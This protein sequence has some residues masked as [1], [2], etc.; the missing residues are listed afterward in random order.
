MLDIDEMSTKEMHDFLQKVGHGHLGCTFEGHP[1][2]VPM[3][4]YFG[5]PNIYI[6]TTIGMKT[7]Y[8]DA[9]PEVCLQVEDVHDL[10]HWRS[11]TVT[12]RAEHITLQQDIDRVMEL[13]KNQNPTLSPAINRTWIDAWGRGEVMALYQIHPTEISGRTTDGISSK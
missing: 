13:V 3:Q 9:N 2:V 8:M 11:V 10:K 4:Y 5:E 7:K 12:G 1:Y 6:F